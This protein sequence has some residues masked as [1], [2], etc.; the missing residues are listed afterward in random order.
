MKGGIIYSK[1]AAY[2]SGVLQKYLHLREGHTAFAAGWRERKEYKRRN[3][4][5]RQMGPHFISGY[6]STHRTLSVGV[7]MCDSLPACGTLHW[8]KSIE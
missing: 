4:I 3:N 1:T 8:R 2:V 5:V 6:E 7:C